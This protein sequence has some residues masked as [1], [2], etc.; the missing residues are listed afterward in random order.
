MGLFFFLKF[1]HVEY[2]YYQINRIGES[3]VL[4]MSTNN[5][6]IDKAVYGKVQNI[7]N[8]GFQIADFNLKRIIK[9]KYKIKLGRKKNED[10]QII[11]K[12]QDNT[13]VKVYALQVQDCIFSEQDKKYVNDKGIIFGIKGLFIERDNVLSKADLIKCLS[14]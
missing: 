9:W 7:K 12:I 8:E 10:K 13:Y 1:F 3:F 11:S 2:E 14:A 6:L 5:N 4:G